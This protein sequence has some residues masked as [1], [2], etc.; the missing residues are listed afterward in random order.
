VHHTVMEY[1]ADS[2]RDLKTSPF[3]PARN[4][5]IRNTSMSK[6]TADQT[7]LQR[8]LHSIVQ[9]GLLLTGTSD[10]ETIVQ[11]TTDAGLEVSGAQF[12][13]FFYNVTNA[14][15]ESYVLYTVSGV[16]REKFSRFPMPRN[17]A[18]FAPT[19]DGTCIVRSGDITKD[20]RYGQN[21]PHF[22]MPKGHLPVHSYLAIPVKARSGEVIG[23]LFY[24]HE[25]TDI[26]EQEAEDLVAAIAGQAAIIIDNRRLREDLNRRIEEQ[27]KARKGEKEVAKRLGELAAIVE[28]SQDVIISKDL[29][30]IIASWNE[31]ATRLFG[32]S[33]DEII[34]KSI[35]TLIPENLHDDEKRIIENV[36][37]GRRVDHF[38]TVRLTKSGEAIEVSV[39]VSPIKNAE[40]EIVGASKILRDISSRR[41]I[42]QSLIQAEKIASVGR[43]AAT[44][45]HEINNP[46]EA[47]TNLLYLLRPSVLDSDAIDLLDTA[48]SELSR[49]SHIARQTLGFYRENSSAGYYSISQLL[50]H[51]ITVYE[52]RCAAFRIK[53]EQSL[54][55]SRKLALRRGEIIQV[56]SNLIANAIYAMPEGGNLNISTLDVNAPRDGVIMTIRDNGVGISAA[57]LPR[58]FEAFFTTRN[59]VG[60]GIGLFVAKQFIESHGGDIRIKSDVSPEVSGTELTVFLPAATPYETEPPAAG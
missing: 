51:A 39:T 15:G 5:T 38:E 43:M 56:I 10:L 34:G 19:F 50:K 44:I 13:A 37:A 36:R 45:A 52:P 41:R 55:S 47:I 35:L 54:E 8:K 2:V 53:I 17:T 42:E 16:D 9:T 27:E 7:D 57:N 30:G 60:T 1:F 59:T 3:S 21:S 26:F 24:G 23:G 33:P 22:G 31:A 11:A 20:V 18:V 28:S 32:Y 49:V 29:N 40:G 4:I 6:T 46:L 12:G 25:E 14:A 58:V 48:E